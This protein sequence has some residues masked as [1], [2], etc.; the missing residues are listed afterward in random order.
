M[1][2][3]ECAAGPPTVGLGHALQQDYAAKVGATLSMIDVGNGIEL[4]VA[5]AGYA[6]PALFS[7]CTSG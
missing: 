3:V 4:E 7:S 6:L 1:E 5:Q 2:S